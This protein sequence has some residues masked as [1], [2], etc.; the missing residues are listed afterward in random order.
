[1]H[2]DG[3][4]SR[5]KCD[6]TGFPCTP[7]CAEWPKI[8]SPQIPIHVGSI[9]ITVAPHWTQTGRHTADGFQDTRELALSIF[10]AHRSI[11]STVAMA[12]MNGS[13]IAWASNHAGYHVSQACQS[14][15]CTSRRI[16][17]QIRGATHT[18]HCYNTK[19]NFDAN[20]TI[21]LRLHSGALL[22][23]TMGCAGGQGPCHHMR[24]PSTPFIS[25]G[26]S[27][28][29]VRRTHHLKSSQ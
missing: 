16:S 5:S 6:T 13:Y 10:M 29:L 8:C 12:P 27:P 15:R 19:R 24:Y 17:R 22:P 21:L 20:A 3:C 23:E 2:S 11:V 18:G 14:N 7:M 4:G 9:W 28:G 1:M 25:I 26:S